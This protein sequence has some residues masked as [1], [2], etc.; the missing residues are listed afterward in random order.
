MIFT[1]YHGI[2]NDFILIDQRRSPIEESTFF[3]QIPRI[4]DRHLGIGADGVLLLESSK[5]SDLQ[6]RIFNSDGSEADMCGNGIRCVADYEIAHKPKIEIETRNGVFTCW[7]KEDQ[8]G[9]DLKQPLICHW[10]MKIHEWSVYVVKVGVPHAV[11]FLSSFDQID[12]IKI[13]QEIRSVFISEGINV[14]FASF[15]KGQ[16]VVRTYERGV[17]NE[18]ISC[19]TGFAAVAFVVSKLYNFPQPILI[20]S[21]S[22][23]M[24]KQMKFF[25]STKGNIQMLAEACRVF[26]GSLHLA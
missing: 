18:T 9:V 2:G 6:M 11:V 8:I 13:A 15:L 26:S 12:L 5:R 22:D 17:E 16:L 23:K 7:R 25:I 3:V 24:T 21:A 4:C 20:A 10:P 14:N 19:G 1:K